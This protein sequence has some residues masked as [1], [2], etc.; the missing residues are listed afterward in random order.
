MIVEIF[1]VLDCT[2]RHNGRK[3]EHSEAMDG[4]VPQEVSTGYY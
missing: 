3:V 4:M 1:L 2:F